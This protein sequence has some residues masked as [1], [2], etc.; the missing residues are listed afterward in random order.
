MK[1]IISLAVLFAGLYVVPANADV[2]HKCKDAQGQM[3]YQASPCARTDQSVS[4]WATREMT[5]EQE[6]GAEPKAKQ[7]LVLRQQG[8]GHYMV[9]GAVN[10]KPLNFIVDTGASAISLPRDLA[11]MANMSCTEQIKVQT[12]NGSSSACMGIISKLKIG[13]YLLR[14]VPAFMAPNLNQPL[15][16]MNVLQRFR[17]EQDNGEMRLTPKE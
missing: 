15:L 12:A 7:A 5:V 14:D 13:P 2:V 1:T 11:Y 8:N 3:R 17:I 16:G 6:P 10:G 4:S 9:T